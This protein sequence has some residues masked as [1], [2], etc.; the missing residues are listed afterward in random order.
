MNIHSGKNGLVA[1]LDGHGACGRIVWWSLQG[2]VT[3]DRLVEEL[4]KTGSK[5]PEPPSKLAALSRACANVARERGLDCKNVRRGEWALVREPELDMADRELI[6][7]VTATAKIVDGQPAFQGDMSDTLRA[8]YDV[9]LTQLSAAEVSAWL[10]SRLDRLNAVALRESG[11]VYFIPA[12]TEPSWDLLIDALRECGQT[13]VFG[14]P[15]MKSEGAIE[16]IVAALT[17]EATAQVDGVLAELAAPE[18]EKLGPRGLAT[19]E[20][21]LSTLLGKIEGY[22]KLLGAKLSELTEKANEARIAVVTAATVVET[23]AQ[24]VAQ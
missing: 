7:G 24:A 20:A 18:D 1:N 11:G 16:A 12:T 22:E 6:Y 17:A 5:A 13:G 3:H 14:V 8:E 15:A 21:S 23:D 9:A 4:A 19:R 10:T 2:S